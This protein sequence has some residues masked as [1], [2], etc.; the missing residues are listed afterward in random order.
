MNRFIS[1][2]ILVAILLAAPTLYASAWDLRELLGKV[3]QQSGSQQSE[4]NKIAGIIDDLFA[5]NNFDIAKLE[6]KWTVSGS[7]VT[8]DSDNVLSKLGGKAATT[9]VQSKLDP[10]F[11]KYGLTGSTITFDK[12]GA[13]S[14]TMKGLTINGTVSKIGDG[15]YQTTFTVMGKGLSP[16]DTYFERGATGN[17]LDVMWDAKRAISLLQSISSVVKLQSL[18]TLSSLLSQYDGIYIGFKLTRT[19]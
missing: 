14:M 4:S 17:T 10:Y 3:G 1:R 12:A 16:M 9:T 7:A 11:Q 6:G 5:S 15:K 8:F 19:E 2:G 18:N 13:F